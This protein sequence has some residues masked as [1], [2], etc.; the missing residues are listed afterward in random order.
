MSARSHRRTLVAS[1]ALTAA[2]LSGCATTGGEEGPP[3]AFRLGSPDFADNT[4]LPMR[5]A[6]NNKANPNC[7]GEND[8]PALAW[9]NAPPKTRSF[10]ILM[11]DQGGR[12]GLGVSHW[13]AYGIPADVTSIARGE[14]GKPPTRW[15]GGKNTIGWNY[16][17]GPCPPRGNAPQ[18]YVYTIIATD[19]EPNAL[20]AGLTKDELIK[21]LNGR[22]LRGASFVTRY[23]H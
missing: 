17:L 1:F 19:V 14:A 6:G 4:M 7:T 11:D 23:A 16:A 5:F 3:S 22:A 15:T 9:R 18:H 10:A 20:P 12:N 8:T 21:A 2:G 13:V